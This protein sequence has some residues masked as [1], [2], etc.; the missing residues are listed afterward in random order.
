MNSRKDIGKILLYVVLVV[1]IFV[2][3]GNSV[4]FATSIRYTARP[5]YVIP[6]ELYELEGWVNNGDYEN[7]IK[8]THRNAILEEKPMSDTSEHEALA[9]YIEAAFDYHALMETGKVEEAAQYYE[10][11]QKELEQI[12]SYRFQEIVEAV[13]VIYEVE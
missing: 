11:I 2:L 1:L 12:E 13:K 4:N 10:M 5:Y 7:L 6:T 9:R 3:A 8:D